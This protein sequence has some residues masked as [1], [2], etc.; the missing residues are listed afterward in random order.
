M[1]ARRDPIG[2]NYCNI[3]SS[4]LNWVI[5]PWPIDFESLVSLAI[6]FDR[7]AIS[8]QV[9]L[10]RQ[11]RTDV[12]SLSSP[13]ANHLRTRF[14]IASV[15]QDKRQGVLPLRTLSRLES[16]AK[17]NLK[18][19]TPKEEEWEKQIRK[20]FLP[21][22]I[23]IWSPNVRLIWIWGTKESPRNQSSYQI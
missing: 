9:F 23:E 2:M 12:A 20:T 13:S 19:S 6:L 16:D 14:F 3:F 1:I 8:I 22:L 15:I 7:W 17:I 4:V 18:N 21:T 11:K 5:N 10:F